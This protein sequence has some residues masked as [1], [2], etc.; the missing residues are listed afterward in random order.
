MVADCGG[1]IEPQAMIMIC[2][3]KRNWGHGWN[4]E[5][6]RIFFNPCSVRG[7]LPCTSIACSDRLRPFPPWVVDRC[8][9]QVKVEKASPQAR[10]SCQFTIS[11]PQKTGVMFAKRVIPCLDVNRGRV[12]KGTNFL[13]LRDAGDPVAVAGATRKKGPTSPFSSISPPATKAAR[14][15]WTLSAARR[16]S[17][18]CR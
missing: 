6:T 7:Q 13:N 12:V 8:A 18:S 1:K 11:Y 17:S 4:T 16:K 2:G 3:A 9:G 15:C 5:E 10:L 14:S